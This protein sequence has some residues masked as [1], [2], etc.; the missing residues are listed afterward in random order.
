MQKGKSVTMETMT[1]WERQ[2]QKEE[3]LIEKRDKRDGWWTKGGG[4]GGGR[5]DGKRSNFPSEAEFLDV[6]GTKV[7]RVFLS[8]SPDYVQK[9]QLNCL[10]WIRLQALQQSK[11]VSAP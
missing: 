11:T 9:P 7:L 3:T 4:G 6:I 8:R 1:E 2:V 5:R 10:S